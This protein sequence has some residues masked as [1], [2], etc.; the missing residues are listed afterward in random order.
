MN[1]LGN[2]QVD[3]IVMHIHFHCAVFILYVGWGTMVFFAGESSE[4]A[5]HLESMKSIITLN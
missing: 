3:H 2:F 4:K 5:C 1:G